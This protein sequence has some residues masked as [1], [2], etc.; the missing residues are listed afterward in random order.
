MEAVPGYPVM[1]NLVDKRCVVV[2]GGQVAARKVTGLVTSGAK[3]T[4]ICPTL[5][6]DLQNRVDTEQVLWLNQPYQSGILSTLQPFLVIAAT[7]SVEV[8]Q[9]VASEARDLSILVNVADNSAERDFRG[10]SAIHRPPL[11]IA[12]STNGASPALVKWLKGRIDD[13]IGAEYETL[14]RWLG[15]LRPQLQSQLSSQAQRAEFYDAVLQS[16]V[17][18]LLLQQQTDAA[19]A[20]LQSLVE[21]WVV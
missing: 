6:L 19:Y 7:D 16:D 1:L 8:N 11:T 2:G 14:A 12:I 10:M 13:C 18:T 20:R 5:T 15:D 3:V 4:V 21:E 17:V 9:S